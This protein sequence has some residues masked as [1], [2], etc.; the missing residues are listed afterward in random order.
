MKQ[1]NIYKSSSWRTKIYL[2]FLNQRNLKIAL[3]HQRSNLLKK[4]N[5]RLRTQYK[6]LQSI[7][8]WTNKLMTLQINKSLKNQNQK[9]LNCKWVRLHQVNNNKKYHH[10]RRILILS[11]RINQMKKLKSK[12]KLLHLRTLKLILNMVGF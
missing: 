12:F 7:V 4:K 6:I 3:V 1:T 8:F 5:K 9:N 10:K 2:I 11:K